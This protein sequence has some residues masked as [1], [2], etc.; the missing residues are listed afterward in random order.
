MQ[1]TKRILTLGAAL[2]FI[3]AGC[4]PATTDTDVDTK[5]T[6]TA[7]DTEQVEDTAAPE[8][9]ETSDTA[10]VSDEETAPEADQVAQAGVYKEWDGALTDTTNLLFFHAPWCSSCS[11]LN[12]DI[13][14]NLGDIPA[15]LTLFKVD[16]DSEKEL[17]K[18]Y[19]VTYQHTMVQVD[20][21]GNMIKKWSGGN[22]LSDIVKKMQ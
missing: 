8:S 5:D 11:A 13:S 12:A 21:D 6:T 16:Y 15:G 4:T 17:K 7:P 19:G 10:A 18:K 14:K 9:A 1:R 20:K 3:G 2:L 22:R